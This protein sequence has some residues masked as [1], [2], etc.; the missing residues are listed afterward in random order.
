MEEGKINDF[1]ICNLH[2]ALMFIY[3]LLLFNLPFFINPS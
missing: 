3:P 2:F 1:A